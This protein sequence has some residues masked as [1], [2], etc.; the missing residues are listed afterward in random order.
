MVNVKKALMNLWFK[1]VRFGVIL[2]MPSRYDA[3]VN[4]YFHKDTTIEYLFKI[5]STDYV[6]I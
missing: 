4:N 3:S 1:F 5:F 6:N 2:G